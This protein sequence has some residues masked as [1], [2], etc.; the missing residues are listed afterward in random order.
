M[1]QYKKFNS[2][3]NRVKFDKPIQ[4]KNSKDF[5]DSDMDIDSSF[6]ESNDNDSDSDINSSSNN[7]SDI[8]SNSENNNESNHHSHNEKSIENGQ[9]KMKN[10]S[11][12]KNNNN[13]GLLDKANNTY[14]KKE[15]I[16]GEKNKKS[17]INKKNKTFKE[18]NFNR[19]KELFDNNINKNIIKE[20]DNNSEDNEIERNKKIEN[21]LLK[22][23]TKKEIITRE[24][25]RLAETIKFKDEP[26]K[27]IFTDEYGF[28]KKDEMQNSSNKIDKRNSKSL[29]KIE[30]S[31]SSKYLLKV[32][33]RMEKWN[34]MLKN[35][36]EFSTKKRNILKS[37]TRKG[38]PDNLRGYVWQLFAEK[39]K[40][41]V[42]DLY[43]NLENQ[44]V[45][46]ELERTIM[47]DLDRT[48]PLISFFRE[49]YGNG[50]RQLYK[51]L[52]S[53]SKYNTKVG[54]VQGMGFM[55]AIFLTYMD[56]ESSFFVLHSLMKKYEMEDIYFDDFPGLR[57]KF[58]ILLNLQK[59]YIPKIYNIFLRDG[60]LPT[61]YA[62]QWFIS[63]FARSLDFDIVLRIFDCFFLEGFKVIYRMSLG[64]LK[65]KENDFCNSDKGCSLPL[66]QTV[67]ENVNTED[68]FN[69][70]FG[71]SIS[72]NFIEKCEAQYDKVKNDEKNEFIAQL[73]F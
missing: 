17:F 65:L 1:L 9:T 10:K 32:N 22:S 42:K 41:Y 38:I 33:A 59:K 16:N 4:K 35:Y 53:Y 24:R 58:F 70:A 39:N 2:F 60:V 34:Y 14:K 6:E 26:D 45:Q 51:V 18:V 68:L 13:K 52:S 15:D 31:K 69:T 66:L 50:Q 25:L 30:S 55:A 11:L 20:N 3:K 28:I 7:E 29:N 73:L 63:L 46:E 57:K 56:E 72:R 19:D 23:I 21:Q 62:S 8:E 71:F 64:L 48:F 54:Y 27:I 36:E 67:L 5:D 12:L 47:K 37:R 49:Q 43:K 40:Y 61:M 44:P